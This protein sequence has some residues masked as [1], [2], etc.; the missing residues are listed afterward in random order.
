MNATPGKKICTTVLERDLVRLYLM[1]NPSVS[2][3]ETVRLAA[4]Y[5]ELL[6]ESRWPPSAR[7]D[8]GD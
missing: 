7:V 1:K 4:D 2:S 6:A 5:V 3:L 8:N